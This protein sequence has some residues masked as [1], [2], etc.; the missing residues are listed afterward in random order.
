MDRDFQTAMVLL[1]VELFD[2]LRGYLAL[3]PPNIL[4]FPSHL[5]RS[6]VDDFLVNFILLNPQFQTYSPSKQYQK[7][8]WKWVIHQLENTLSDEACSPKVIRTV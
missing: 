2:L 5:P 7:S 6:S 1:H 4:S 8:F 3:V